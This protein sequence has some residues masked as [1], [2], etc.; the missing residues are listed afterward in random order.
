[1]SQQDL[2]LGLE[3]LKFE[4][5]LC[6]DRDCRVSRAGDKLA[7]KANAGWDRLGSARAWFPFLIRG[8]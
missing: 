7:A 6:S 1:M 3:T 4:T 2:T 8:P 5:E